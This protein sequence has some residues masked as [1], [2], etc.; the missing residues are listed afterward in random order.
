MDNVLQGP[1]L[2]QICYCTG[3]TTTKPFSPNNEK[4]KQP[5]FLYC[6]LSHLE[7]FVHH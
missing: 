3:T 6:M 2:G 7:H 1:P 5:N 4:P